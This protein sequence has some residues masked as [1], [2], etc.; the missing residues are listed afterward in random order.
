MKIVYSEHSRV[1]HRVVWVWKLELNWRHFVFFW[2][3]H[4]THQEIRWK[5][6]VSQVIVKLTYLKRWDKVTQSNDSIS[7]NNVTEKKE[8]NSHQKRKTRFFGFFA[9]SEEWRNWKVIQYI[10]KNYTEAF[11]VSKNTHWGKVRCFPEYSRDRMC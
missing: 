7:E 9:Q 10:L 11:F 1:L 4:G 6:P 3:I 2:R 5:N 8:R